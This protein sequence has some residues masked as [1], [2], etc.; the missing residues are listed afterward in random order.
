MEFYTHSRRGPL[1]QPA[2]PRLRRPLLLPA[3]LP[4]PLRAQQVLGQAAALPLRDLQPD[5]SLAL[6]HLVLRPRRR[7]RGLLLDVRSKLPNP[8]HCS[9]QEEEHRQ[10][11]REKTGK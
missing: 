10:E 11:R 4:F 3:G 8:G 5:V 9:R 6:V 1:A 7:V 2:Q